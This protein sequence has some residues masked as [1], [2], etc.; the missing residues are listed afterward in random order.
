M[1]KSTISN[2]AVNTA[3]AG[4]SS[5]ELV[6]GAFPDSN[7][8]STNETLVSESAKS[9]DI[10][11]HNP[12]L[13][14][15]LTM[16]GCNGAILL[17]ADKTKQQQLID[18]DDH[19]DYYEVAFQSSYQIL[20]T[21]SRKQ[22]IKLSNFVLT[23]GDNE[24]FTL[25]DKGECAGVFQEHLSNDIN[26]EMSCRASDIIKTLVIELEASIIEASGDC[27]EVSGD[28]ATKDKIVLTLEREG[29]FGRSSFASQI[30]GNIKA[31]REAKGMTQKEAAAGLKIPVSSIY[32]SES[33]NEPSI[34]L[35]TRICDFYGC[36]P[37]D[38]LMRDRCTPNDI[39]MQG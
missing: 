33:Y 23:L 2:I 26:H 15:E 12:L 38:I 34:R 3:L 31:A 10:A 6:K 27:I 5:N 21:N 20:Y 28:D 36:T 1:S 17:T 4:I 18:S 24:F 25:N 7:I 37:N 39:P 19:V 29:M 8:L 13:E 22:K 9:F 30:S 14:A 11:I 16:T 32:D 35:V